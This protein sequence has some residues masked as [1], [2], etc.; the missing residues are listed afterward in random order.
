[1]TTQTLPTFFLVQH[2]DP[3]HSWLAVPRDLIARLG[4][5][6]RVSS[7]SYADDFNVYLEEDDDMPLFEKAAVSSAIDYFVEELHSNE[8][9][10]VRTMR[11]YRAPSNRNVCA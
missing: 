6:E 2:I 8:L 5:A 9:S 3:A 1:M 4:L 11:R 10:V 7:C